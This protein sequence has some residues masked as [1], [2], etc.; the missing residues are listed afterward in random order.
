RSQ[1]RAFDLL[2]STRV[3][4][5]FDLDRE[6]PRLRER[7]GKTLFGNCALI[8]RRLVEAGGR[9]WDGAGGPFWGRVPVNYDSWDTH[10]RNFP[11]LRDVNLPEFDRV[12]DALLQDLHDRGLLDET[13][14]IVLSEM[15]RTARIN[16]AG[17]RDHWTFCY[18]TWLTGAGIKGGSI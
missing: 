14:V 17:G 9:F 6:D 12:Q 16:P 7:Y 15:G 13:L 10:T 11:I 18:G 8:A 3:R 5:A 2:T 1:S 4:A